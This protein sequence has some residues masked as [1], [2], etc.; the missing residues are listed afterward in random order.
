MTCSPS[1]PPYNDQKARCEPFTR[2]VRFAYPEA[3][4]FAVWFL[5]WICSRGS[6]LTNSC[7]FLAV[8]RLTHCYCYV[9]LALAI[10]RFPAAPG[11]H[12]SA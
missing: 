4:A 3:F 8:F 1:K 5:H 7:A 12:Y 9:F 10:L 2:L 6:V 11:V